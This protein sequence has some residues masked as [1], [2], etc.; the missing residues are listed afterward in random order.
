MRSI[1]HN[2]WGTVL[3]S[4][5]SCTAACSKQVSAI[6]RDQVSVAINKELP[7]GAS[8]AEIEKFFKRHHIDFG[9]N[10]F[11]GVYNGV[12]RDVEPFHGITLVVFV[13]KD[14]RFVKAEVKDAYT[15]P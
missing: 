4:F 15:A 3:L 6:T 9:W 1:R 13:D 10:R 14:R 12:I 5:L 2:V 8:A 7:V 11:E